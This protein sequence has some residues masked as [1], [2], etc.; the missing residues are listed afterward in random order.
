MKRSEETVR[1]MR[2]DFWLCGI[3]N[4]WKTIEKFMN[5]M[6]EDGLI[7][8]PFKKEEIFHNALLDT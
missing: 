5:Y 8:R 1:L 3:K 4:N 7:K 2:E 6:I